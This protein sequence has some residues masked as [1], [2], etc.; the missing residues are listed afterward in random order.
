MPPADAAGAAALGVTAGASAAL[1]KLA[2]DS[3]R[4]VLVATLNKIIDSI[5]TANYPIGSLY[6]NASVGTDPRQLLGYGVWER[7]GKGRTFISLDETQSPFDTVGETGYSVYT[8]GS[9]T[10]N[11][12]PY[13]VVYVWRRIG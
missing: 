13:V 6:F 4:E 1:V 11:T 8:S 9:G 3:P 7:F 2:I 10:S 12:N 5:N